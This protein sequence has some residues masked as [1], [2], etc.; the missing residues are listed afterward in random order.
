MRDGAFTK[1]DRQ[2]V[3][4]APLIALFTATPRDLACVLWHSFTVQSL[5]QA[6]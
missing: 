3:N 5:E 1:A 6:C 2:S 4:S